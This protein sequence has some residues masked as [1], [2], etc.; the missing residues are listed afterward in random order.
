MPFVCLPSMAFRDESLAD[1]PKSR[2][3]FGKKRVVSPEDS[4]AVPKSW[5]DFI[6]PANFSKIE[7]LRMVPPLLGPEIQANRDPV[8]DCRTNVPRGRMIQARFPSQ[9]IRP[10]AFTKKGIRFPGRFT[11]CQIR[12]FRA[13]PSSR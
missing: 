7:Q 3:V 6:F 5:T 13:Y 1:Q 10:D 8:G 9:R 4:A 12:R 11:F 2:V